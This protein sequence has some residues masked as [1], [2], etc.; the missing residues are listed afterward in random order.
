ML[1]LARSSS[2]CLQRV[3]GQAVKPDQF[4]QGPSASPADDAIRAQPV[5]CGRGRQTGR[6][7]NEQRDTT[8][9]CNHDARSA[10]TAFHRPRRQDKMDKTSRCLVERW[11]ATD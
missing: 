8:A 7:K 2:R 4:A 9:N 1:K 10:V 11:C 6:G 3:T 5:P